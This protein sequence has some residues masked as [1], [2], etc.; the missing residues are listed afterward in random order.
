MKTL[1]LVN[2]LQE[3]WHKTKHFLINSLKYSVLIL[4]IVF[5]IIL[6]QKYILIKKKTPVEN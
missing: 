6:I 4:I 1:K 2:Q 5:F 3:N